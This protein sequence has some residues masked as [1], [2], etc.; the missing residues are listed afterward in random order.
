MGNYTDKEVSQNPQIEV[1]YPPLNGGQQHL[2]TLVA[3]VR[4]SVTYVIIILCLLIHF[5]CS[6]LVLRSRFYIAVSNSLEYFAGKKIFIL[7]LTMTIW[8]KTFLIF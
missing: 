6:V 5:W 4:S 3:F 1:P 7:C 8:A 2:G